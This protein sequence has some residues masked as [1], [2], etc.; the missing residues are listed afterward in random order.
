MPQHMC[1]TLPQATA[2]LPIIPM[3][4]LNGCLWLDEIAEGA[5]EAIDEQ[6][7]P[8]S[9][10][11]DAGGPYTLSVGERMRLAATVRLPQT[12]ENIS[13]SWTIVPSQATVL[14]TEAD[15]LR[16]TI[17]GQTPGN[18]LLQLEVH[19]TIDEEP[20]ASR[21][22]LRDVANVSVLAANN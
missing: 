5:A 3:M 11:I 18:T 19:F 22:R 14:L 21:R 12:A 4:L 16:P 2:V 1:R 7:D 13:T 8:I 6:L 17:S 10:E 20:S 15:T 9:T